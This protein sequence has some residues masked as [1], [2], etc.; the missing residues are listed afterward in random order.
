MK[1]TDDLKETILNTDNKVLGTT[2]PH[3]LNV[4][5]VSTVFVRDDQIWLVNYFFSKTAENLQAKSRVVFTCWQD[6]AV[7]CQIKGH[8]SYIESGDDFDEIGEWAAEKLPDRTVHAIVKITPEEVH[9]VA[10][11]A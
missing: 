7:G 5:P 8:A 6:L 1:I 4:V 3:G 10:P 2:G 11:K 9:N